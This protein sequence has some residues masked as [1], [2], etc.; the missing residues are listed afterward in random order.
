MIIQTRMRDCSVMVNGN[1]DDPAPTCSGNSSETR[2]IANPLATDT[3]DTTDTTD[4][5]DAV[6]SQWSPVSNADTRVLM[7]T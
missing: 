5:A 2:T 6:W 1:T 4:V 7:I 3:T